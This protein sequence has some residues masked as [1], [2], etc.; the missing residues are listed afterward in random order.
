MAAAAESRW[1]NVVSFAHCAAMMGETGK[2]SRAYADRGLQRLRE[3][4]LAVRAQEHVPPRERARDGHRHDAL[5][6]PGA[7]AARLQRLARHERAGASAR[8]ER[9]E[10]LLFGEPDDREH[11]AADA[12]H[13]RLGHAQHG[14][15]G[16][17]GVDGVAALPQDLEAG[18]G[19]ERLARRDRAVGR[20]DGGAA[21]QRGGPLGLQRDGGRRGARRA[22][23]RRRS[24]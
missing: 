23:R 13:V 11:V 20:V 10:L 3:R 8:V 15:G 19:G 24:S 16:D 5:L 2:P 22:R 18:R 14:R 9:D 17:G 7:E 21:G 4:A 12:G 1:R 6:R